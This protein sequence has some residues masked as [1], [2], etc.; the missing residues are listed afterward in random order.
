M[1]VKDVGF[2]FM[3]SFGGS[4]HRVVRTRL[5]RHRREGKTG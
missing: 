5:P 1:R 4:P 3:I 2:G